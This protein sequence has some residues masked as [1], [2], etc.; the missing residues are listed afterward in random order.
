MKKVKIYFATALVMGLSMVQTGCYGPFKLTK[1]IYDW[2]GEVSDSGIIRSI[3]FVGMVIIPV[4]GL[5][6][7]I[8]AIF[9]NSIEF[10]T[11]SNPVS[12]APGE[13]EEQIV[14][15]P[16]GTFKLTATTNQLVIKQISGAYE[17][18]EVMMQYRSDNQWYLV[19]GEKETLLSTVESP[20]DVFKFN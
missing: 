7:F 12:L 1:S 11:G 4:Y 13:V 14:S 17:G 5:S 8:D 3:L 6:L 19:S 10:W 15:T 9:L 16:E 18:K 20:S 2:N